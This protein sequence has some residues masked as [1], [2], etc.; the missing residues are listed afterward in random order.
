VVFRARSRAERD[1]WVLAIQNEIEKVQRGRNEDF[2]IEEGAK[3][4]KDQAGV[5]AAAAA[6]ADSGE[7]LE[8]RTPAPTAAT[9]PA[10][11]T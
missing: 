10:T 6:G 2:R 9:T 7:A 11:A 4:A 8:Q 1:H 5:E 3:Q